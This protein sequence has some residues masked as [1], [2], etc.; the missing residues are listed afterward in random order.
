MK[1]L[2]L[3][4]ELLAEVQPYGDEDKGR[5]DWGERTEDDKVLVR[6]PAVLRHAHATRRTR[7]DLDGDMMSIGAL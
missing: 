1:P 4:K 7:D 5:H 3:R 6:L 2:H